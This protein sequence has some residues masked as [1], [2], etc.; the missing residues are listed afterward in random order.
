[1]DAFRKKSCLK[2]PI[3]NWGGLKSHTQKKKFSL[4]D[5]L[6]IEWAKSQLAFWLYSLMM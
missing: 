5:R 2:N 3:I 6:H 1:M 4:Q